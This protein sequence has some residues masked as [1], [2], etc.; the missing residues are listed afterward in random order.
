MVAPQD[1]VGKCWLLHVPY[2]SS[3]TRQLMSLTETCTRSLMQSHAGADNDV[4]L[5]FDSF[6]VTYLYRYLKWKVL[7]LLRS[8][9]TCSSSLEIL[10]KTEREGVLHLYSSWEVLDD[11]RKCV[12]SSWPLLAYTLLDSCDTFCRQKPTQNVTWR[13]FRPKEVN[14]IKEFYWINVRK[15][16]CFL[17][18]DT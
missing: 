3:M 15:C 9:F 13:G 5:K 2:A 14:L 6:N 18:G 10:R 8:S 16:R 1:S 12:S 11:T 4:P 7:I 17:E